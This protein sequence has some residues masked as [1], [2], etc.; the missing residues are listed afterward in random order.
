L[1]DLFL[2]TE[3]RCFIPCSKRQKNRSKNVPEVYNRGQGGLLDIVLHPD[4][5]TNGWIYISYA[6]TEAQAE[7]L[8]SFVQN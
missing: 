7:T 1:P 6:S 5:A 4:Y 2:V 3:K 8:K